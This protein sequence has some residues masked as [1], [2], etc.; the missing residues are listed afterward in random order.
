MWAGHV[1][2]R[3][4][5]FIIQN[6]RRS[7]ERRWQT[8]SHKHIFFFFFF[9]DVHEEKERGKAAF[10]YLGW[11]LSSSLSFSERTTVLHKTGS[12]EAWL[13]ASLFWQQDYVCEC[14]LAWVEGLCFLLHA[15][16]ST[17]AAH[18]NET[19]T[20]SLLAAWLGYR[21]PDV[22][23]G[24]F[25]ILNL[26]PFPPLYVTDLQALFYSYLTNTAWLLHVE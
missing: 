22:S 9:W 13:Y 4:H 19:I 17:R 18:S 1:W 23:F 21:F 6:S 24:A 7:S 14:V 16:H 12:P 10:F 8:T 11:V 2:A 5:P 26:E 25:K 15:D 20:P 3:V